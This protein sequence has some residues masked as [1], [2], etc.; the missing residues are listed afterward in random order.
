MAQSSLAEHRGSHRGNGSSFTALSCTEKQEATHGG[1]WV[2]AWKSFQNSLTPALDAGY[3]EMTISD[4]PQSRLQ[5]YRLTV[6]VNFQ[7][8]FTLDFACVF[9]IG[10]D[11]M[12]PGGAV[13]TG[14]DRQPGLCGHHSGQI[15]D[16]NP[17]CQ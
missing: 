16:G 4:K 17:F 6:R 13:G 15:P 8:R 7:R 5:K 9:L 1:S 3:I 2:K 11:A 14:T 12:E 10:L